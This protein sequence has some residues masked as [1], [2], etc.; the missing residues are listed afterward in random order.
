MAAALRQCNA[1]PL[2][3]QLWQS[4]DAQLQRSLMT[5]VSAVA[6]AGGAL[7]CLKCYRSRPAIKVQSRHSFK[8][9]TRLDVR[10]TWQHGRPR[11]AGPDC[12]PGG[13]REAWTERLLGLVLREDTPAPLRAAA[14]D[15]LGGAAAAPPVH[16]A[17][18]AHST[19][20]IRQAGSEVDER[21]GL[22]N[23]GMV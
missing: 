23:V 8:R 4:A 18:L 2:A 14:G 21:A 1:L 13:Q 20:S 6:L 15:A 16:L 5:A 11:A 10:F 17:V 19:D 7:S 9:A 12:M 22:R 3:A